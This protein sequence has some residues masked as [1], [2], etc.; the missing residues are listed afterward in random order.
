M[1]HR[2]ESH[3]RAV[4]PCEKFA[5]G[6]CNFNPESCWWNHAEN[7]SEN[8]QC[9]I[10]NQTFD[11][12]IDMMG[13]RKKNHPSIIQRCSKFERGECRFQKD[14]CWFIHS[15][16]T[17][18]NNPGESKDVTGEAETDDASDTV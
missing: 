12:K 1:K 17:K 9:F 13:H 2:K 11:N 3:I 7:I 16:V 4:G 6:N 15:F 5:E 10:C 18:D 8:I 14:Y